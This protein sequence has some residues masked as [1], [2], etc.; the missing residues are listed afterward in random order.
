MEKTQNSGK[1]KA[2]RDKISKFAKM[3]TVGLRQAKEKVTQAII[4]Q[5]QATLAS[6]KIF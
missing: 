6:T 3:N 4:I 1:V 2:E 5:C